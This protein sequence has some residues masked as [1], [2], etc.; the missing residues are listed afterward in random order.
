MQAALS[1]SHVLVSATTFVC[2]RLTPLLQR[3]IAATA[4]QM[5]L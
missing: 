5:V 3:S 2:Q 1:A 4:A